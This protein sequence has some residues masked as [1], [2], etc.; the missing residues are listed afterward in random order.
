MFASESNLA[1]T[2]F[3]SPSS[4]LVSV[5]FFSCA[6][7]P[8][9]WWSLFFL[10]SVIDNFCGAASLMALRASQSTHF[11]YVAMTVFLKTVP[12]HDAQIHKSR[13]N[14]RIFFVRVSVCTKDNSLP[15]SATRKWR[16]N[17]ICSIIVGKFR[18]KAKLFQ[19]SLPTF[20]AERKKKLSYA[21]PSNPKLLYA[22]TCA[23]A[24]L[25]PT[26]TFN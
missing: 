22:H 1:R 15:L 2:A 13:T 17:I 10:T 26:Y 14:L 11:T 5:D 18:G 16:Y 24:R 9:H 8:P 3:I 4:I 12:L 25:H 21:Y 23:L 7:S 6:T 20:F 19:R